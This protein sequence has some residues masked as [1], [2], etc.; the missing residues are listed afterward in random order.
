MS[1][2]PVQPQTKNGFRAQ[3]A[4]IDGFQQKWSSESPN[5]LTALEGTRFVD[6]AANDHP[7]HLFLI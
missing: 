7:D 6:L 2:T 1:E 3:K 5:G 4:K